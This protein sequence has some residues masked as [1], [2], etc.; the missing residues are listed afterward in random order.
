[1]APAPGPQAAPA[2]PPGAPPAVGQGGPALPGP[3]WPPQPV[4]PPQGLRAGL[5]GMAPVAYAGLVP[6]GIPPGLLPALPSQ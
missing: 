5:G 2:G 3:G 1:M 4:G 6:G